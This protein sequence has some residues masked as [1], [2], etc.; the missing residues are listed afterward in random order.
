MNARFSLPVAF[1]VVLVVCAGCAPQKAPEPGG[2]LRVVVTTGMIADAV[3]NIAGDRVEVCALMG[4][5]VDPH[6]YK[7]S[8]GDVLRLSA[9]HLILYSGH[10]LE[11]RMTDVFAR[12][13]ESGWRTVALAEAIDRKDLLAPPGFQ[14]QYDP[15]V[16]FDVR[17]WMRVVERARESLVEAVPS[18]RDEISSAAARYLADLA[19]LHDYVT[20]RAAEL[21]PERRVLV[22]AHDAFGYFGRAYGFEVRGLQGIST[23]AEAGTADVQSLARFIAERRV[24]AIFV[25]SSVPRRTVEA[26]Q[27][28]VRARGFRVRIGPQLYADALGSPGTPEGTYI[29]MVKHNIDT[30][31]AA[32]KTESAE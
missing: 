5:G 22:T 21:P 12:M 19:A 10:H 9:A 1:A 26:L 23:A 4:S 14:G 25:E 31:V 27:E 17:L 2:T 29:G 28:A 3:C 24:S 13:R 8:E 15:H 30:I 18:H 16:W 7:P 32:L 20:S 6:L 11:A